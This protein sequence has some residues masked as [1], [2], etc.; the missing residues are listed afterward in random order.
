MVHSTVKRLELYLSAPLRWYCM[1]ANAAYGGAFVEAGPVISR[2]KYRANSN[3]F[4]KSKVNDESKDNQDCNEAV[5][6]EASQETIRP[7][8]RKDITTNVGFVLGVGRTLI[9]EDHQLTYG[10]GLQS[11]RA[12]ANKGKSQNASKRKFQNN[13]YIYL[14]WTC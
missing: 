14:S 9:Y 8:L 10:L 13:T 5:K 4:D 11:V 7:T 6:K 3:R 12:L 1:T 2:I